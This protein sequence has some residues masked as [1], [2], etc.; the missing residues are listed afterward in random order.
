VPPHVDPAEYDAKIK[1]L[2]NYVP[3][4]KR[5][6]DNLMRTAHDDDAGKNSEHMTRLKLFLAGV[7]DPEKR[8]PMHILDR[9]EDVLR[10]VTDANP[11]S[12]PP[13][14]LDLEPSSPPPSQNKLYGKRTKVVFEDRIPAKYRKIAGDV[15]CMD[16]LSRELECMEEHFVVQTVKKPTDSDKKVEL[17]CFIEDDGLPKVPPLKITLTPSYPDSC[18]EVDMKEYANSFK[19]LDI[20]QQHLNKWMQSQ[21]NSFLLSNVLQAWESSVKLALRDVLSQKE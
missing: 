20:I 13:A 15:T 14:V 2:L 9:W 8:L 16:F 10:K 7:Q 4:V 5:M 6:I 11:Q 12:H 1:E 19:F 3:L 18:P 17:Q 21:A